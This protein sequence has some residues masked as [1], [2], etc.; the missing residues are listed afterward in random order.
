MKL[1]A[2]TLMAAGIL[3][4]SSISMEAD[5]QG[6]MGH[7]LRAGA[8][9]EGAV[10]GGRAHP[11]LDKW[12][13]MSPE[14]REQW[15]KD[16]PEAVTRAKAAREKWANMTPEQK[17]SAI[18]RLRKAREGRGGGAVGG[19]GFGGQGGMTPTGKE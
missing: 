7:R 4:I 14:Q 12:R 17:Q 16:H 11:G 2:L 3:A 5:A 9:G 19:G 10:G 18:E 13:Q 6:L 8:G 15:K 1:S